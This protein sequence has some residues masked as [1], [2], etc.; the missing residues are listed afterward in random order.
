MPTDSHQFVNYFKAVNER[1]QYYIKV[2]TYKRAANRKSG[3]GGIYILTPELRREIHGNLGRI[4]ELIANA[5]LSETKREALS[6]KLHAFA[7]EVDK[8]RTKIEA[9]AAAIIW[10]RKQVEEGAKNLQP[11]VDGLTKMFES[12]AKA[13]EFLKLPSSKETKKLPAPPKRIE[14]PKRD[15]DDEVPF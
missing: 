8:N 4:R 6:K 10:S 3:I 13:T 7:E 11:I 1:I 14:G 5:D 12:M 2:T 9:L 15:L